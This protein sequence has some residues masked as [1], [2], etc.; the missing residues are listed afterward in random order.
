[1]WFLVFIFGL[2]I[3]SFLNVVI[4]RLPSS[5]TLAGRSVCPKCK[6]QLQARD[7]VPLFSFV[8]LRGRCRHCFVPI[9][10]RYP[11]I[12]AV[13]G[14]LFLLSYLH[15]SYS[16]GGLNVL[17]LILYFVVCS[18]ALVTFVIDLEHYLIL[19]KIT[20]TGLGLVV[21]V[22]F[23]QA[24]IGKDFSML[25]GRLVGM[26]LGTLPLFLIWWL[27]RGKWMG[28]GDVK[29]MLFIGWVVGWPLVIFAFVLTFWLGTLIALPL[30]LAGKKQLS[31]KMPLGT[32]M[33]L[34]LLLVIF[35]G[36]F[37][38]NFASKY[39]FLSY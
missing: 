19:D 27:S 22:V 32:F 39:I 35:F 30:L 16:T 17:D 29:F 36:V 18:V 31:G 37:I 24:F 28:F 11:L 26:L 7:L 14:I 13:T 4:L 9:H 33:A 8:F 15:L 12:E 38:Q 23:I 3:G 1:M 10:Y 5:K 2:L 21:L 34:S 25:L 20:F 6:H